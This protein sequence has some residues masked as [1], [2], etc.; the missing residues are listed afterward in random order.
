MANASYW[1]DDYVKKICT[2]E[3]AIS[4]I[5]SGQR[6]FIGSSCGEPQCLVRGLYDGARSFTDLEIVR[7][8]ASESTALTSIA[9][10]TLSQAM[11]IRSFYLGSVKS[12]ELAKNIRF[13]TPI[14][15]SQVPR[16][17]K[18]RKLPL[19]VALIQVTPP[20]D[21]GWMN[22]GVSVDVTL[23]AALSA[24]LVIA[25]V[26]SRMPWVLGRGF[27]HANDVDVIVE[28]DEDLLT[29]GAPP[30]SDQA[31]VIGRHIANLIDDGSTIQISLGT[32]SH[33]TLV[34]LADKNDLGVHSQFLTNGMM[35]L[36][37]RGVI[38]NRKK[39]FND[40]KLVASI[41]IGTRELYQFLHNNPG[42]EFH[43]SDYVNDPRIIARHNKM[44]CMN[45]AMAMDLTG[46]VAADALPVNH[47]SGLTGIQDFITGTSLCED[48]KFILMLTS[49]AAGGKQSRIVP[50]LH[51]TAVVVPRGEVQYVIT[52]YGAVNL[53][54]KSYQERALALISIA[55]PD[56]REELFYEAKKMGLLGLE[57]TFNESIYG[58]YPVRMEE[59]VEID[60]EA[61]TFRPT[62]PVDERLLQEHLYNLDEQDVVS[63]FFGARA[64][65][66]QTDVEGISRTDYIKSLTVVAVVGKVGFE[67]IVGI[68]EY[69]LEE[70]M[71]MAEVAFSVN[72]D[73][74]GR[75]LGRVLIAKLAEAAREN[76]IAGLLAYTSSE[77]LRMMKLFRTLPYKIRSVIG[78][79][80]VLSL[81]FDEPESISL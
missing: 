64:C 24:D 52:E 80:V 30:E 1:A 61:V 79:E 56:F 2:V 60:G 15:L 68:G 22:L 69:H 12:K 18:S 50:T 43:P 4:L 42:V 3:K 19:H 46:Q 70:A 9:N 77:N 25:Q 40:G 36:V 28:H 65:F 67:K 29:I 71:N 34:A 6:V 78:E 37:S 44:V 72:K 49:T 47:Y 5:K 32:T 35:D 39:G 76:G 62:K 13:L 10:K 54:G 55:H 38:T 7:L 51:D 41:A 26:N 53:F 57:R 66:L 48:G 8:F 16:M 73:W 17:F 45:V 75:G 31:D 63:R 14:N 21:F 20:D 33:A 59:T 74:Q 11:N 27:I 23:S 58:I 81:R